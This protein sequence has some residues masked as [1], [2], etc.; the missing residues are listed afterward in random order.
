[1]LTVSPDSITVHANKTC[2][3]RIAGATFHR[4]ARLRHHD[5]PV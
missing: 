3:A 2:S 5:D 4:A 1:M